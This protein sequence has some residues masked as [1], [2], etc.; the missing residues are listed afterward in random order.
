MENK[1]HFND[2]N[3]EE[4]A[5][6]LRK[7]IPIAN[8]KITS[9]QWEEYLHKHQE[10][11]NQL[12]SPPMTKESRETFSTN[13]ETNKINEMNI[14]EL[15]NTM[16]ELVSEYVA[17][18]LVTPAQFRASILRVINEEIKYHSEILNLVTELK[19]MVL[20]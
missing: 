3:L 18:K 16:A 8:E 13:V 4:L 20:G 2:M 14:K 12:W 15:D 1:E 17:E 10:V 9:K 7:D 6:E 5:D 11:V 19:S